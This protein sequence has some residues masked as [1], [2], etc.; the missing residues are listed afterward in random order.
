M[1][2]K[3]EALKS[4]MIGKIR[5]GGT[6]FTTRK[7]KYVKIGFSQPDNCYFARECFMN[8]STLEGGAYSFGTDWFDISFH[9]KYI[10]IY[11][12]PD[13]FRQWP[14]SYTRERG[15]RF[16]K[17]EETTGLA[18]RMLEFCKRAD[19]EALSGIRDAYQINGTNFD[20]IISVKENLPQ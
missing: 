5:G 20:H 13:T 11:V 6:W 19:L 4:E 16:D 3:K 10:D 7:D 9:G 15:T 18:E 14:V 8:D 1:S 2:S 12:D 17:T